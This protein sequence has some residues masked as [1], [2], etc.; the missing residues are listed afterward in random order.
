MSADAFRHTAAILQ[1]AFS[2]EGIQTVATSADESLIGETFPLLVSAA[3]QG[4]QAGNIR[5]S[6]FIVLFV[7]YP[8]PPLFESTESKK[9]DP[10]STS[11]VVIKSAF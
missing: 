7:V 2:L 10:I 1:R 9:A 5:D 11:R 3:N 6:F 8:L 4:G